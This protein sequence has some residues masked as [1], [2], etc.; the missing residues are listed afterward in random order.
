MTPPLPPS[1]PSPVTEHPAPTGRAAGTCPWNSLSPSPAGF[2]WAG[3]G[4]E[5][6]EDIK[7]L[8]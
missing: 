8:L 7:F 5:G 1:K 3:E 4:E 2:F 6:E